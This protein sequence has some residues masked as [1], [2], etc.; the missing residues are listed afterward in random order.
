MTAD[1]RHFF[2]INSIKPLL[3]VYLATFD[4]SPLTEQPL[5]PLA[6]LLLL[7]KTVESVIV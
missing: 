2:F 3:S 6:S 4:L 1:C 5:M 7:L